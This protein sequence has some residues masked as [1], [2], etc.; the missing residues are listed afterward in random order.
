[1]V[2]LFILHQSLQNKH[3]H[4][5]VN[6]VVVHSHPLNEND[7]NPV[8]NHDHTKAELCLYHL[9]NFDYFS[10]AGELHFEAISTS[11]P[12]ITISF[13]ENSYYDICLCNT[14]PRGPPVIKS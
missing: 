8:K 14:D 13:K 11:F 3:T 6:G 1:M 9:L 5:Y 4:F 2:F 12:E 10:H 7:K